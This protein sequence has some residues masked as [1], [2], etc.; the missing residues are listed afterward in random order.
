[1]AK[2]AAPYFL[3]G[4]PDEFGCSAFRSFIGGIVT[5][6]DHLFCSAAGPDNS[7]GIV[8]NDWVGQQA[9]RDGKGAPHIAVYDAVG[10]INLMRLCV[11]GGYSCC[12]GS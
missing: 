7:H 11:P 1:M 12:R 2:V 10:L 3:D 4:I 8:G 6:E 9:V 5:D